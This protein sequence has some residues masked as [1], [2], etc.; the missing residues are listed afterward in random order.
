MSSN[1]PKSN[2]ENIVICQGCGHRNLLGTL[3]C[4]NC[5]VML[6]IE[7]R[8]GGTKNLTKILPEIKDGSI[9][10]SG[11]DVFTKD[12]ELRVVI[13]SDE[14]RAL[15]FTPAKHKML[16]VGRR[17][18]NARARPH[19]DLEDYD[20]YRYG[21]S[22]KHC[23]ILFQDRSLV[24]QDYGSANGTFLNGV[25]LPPHNPHTVSDGDEIRLGNLSIRLF[26]IM[27]DDTQS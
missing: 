4:A 25:R 6:S 24:V 9:F 27:P 3:L 1:F 19:I 11:S 16:L 10:S 12:M 23:V 26:F 15:L 8:T 20:G 18:P 14:H 13:D 5:G 2:D 17:D 21:V 7:T 22:R